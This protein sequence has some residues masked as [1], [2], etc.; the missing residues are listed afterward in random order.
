MLRSLVASVLVLTSAAAVAAPGAIRAEVNGM[1]CAFCAAGIEK[2]LRALDGTRDVYV[3]LGK[4]IVA[5]GAKD[6]RELS[7]EQVSAAIKDAGYEVRSIQ[8]TDQPLEAIR[9]EF[10]RR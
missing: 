7:P 2:K 4:K 8:R 1:V 10:G 5:V 9:A 3:N 6:G